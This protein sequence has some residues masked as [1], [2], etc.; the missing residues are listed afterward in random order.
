MND[1]QHTSRKT[2]FIICWLA[3]V[4]MACNLGTS[5]NSDPPTI[6]PRDTA[7]PPPTLGF[8]GQAPAGSGVV[9]AGIET[10]LPNVDVALYNLMETVDVDRLMI[11]IRSLQDFETR[12]VNSEKNSLTRGIGA[13]RTYIQQEFETIQA[14]SNGRFNTFLYPFT[15]NF[16]GIT[17]QQDNVVGVIQ[18]T[19]LNAS[20]VV[21]GAHY[22]SIGPN[23]GNATM[24]APGA[25]DNGSGVAALIELAR[26]MSTRQYRSTV[27]F[28]A[29]SAE[30]VERQGSKAFANYMSDRSIDIVGM[31][32][33]DTIGNI[34][35]SNGEINRTDL[36]VFSQEAIA[37]RHMARTAEFLGFIHGAK[38]DLAVQE[39]EDRE[40]R[41]GDHMSF[42]DVGYPAIRV[43]NALEEFPNGSQSD[44]IEFVEPDYLLN[45]VQSILIIIVAWADGPLPPRNVTLR[46]LGDGR[47]ALRWDEVPG[48]AGYVIALR[49]PGSLKYDQHIEWNEPS[50]SWDGFSS[51]AGVAVAAR[52]ADGIIGRLSADYPLN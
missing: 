28:V 32:N 5:G 44:V 48:A 21:I 39:T 4:L 31:I 20:T 26:I 17:A 29:F 45:A 6:V 9:A 50:I 2:L 18:G 33:I 10:P 23:F 3:L 52:G 47:S 46:D 35:G 7:T 27:M 38:L 41:Y 37:S 8:N 22:D 24:F 14:N 1:K 42:T 49:W 13:A 51:Y 25:N 34:N 36:R 40:G 30:E 43:I 19:E 16:N 11:H 12:H 15:S